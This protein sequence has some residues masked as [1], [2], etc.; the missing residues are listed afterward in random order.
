MTEDKKVYGPSLLEDM[1][2]LQARISILE[3]DSIYLKS[4]IVYWKKRYEDKIFAND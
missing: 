1:L 3:E 4:Q 2:R